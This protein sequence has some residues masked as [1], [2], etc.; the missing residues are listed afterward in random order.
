MIYVGIDNGLYGAIA[1]YRKQLEVYPIPL[2]IKKV[3][4][5]EREF[6]DKELIKNIFLNVFFYDEPSIIVLEEAQPF[7]KEGATSSF[8]TGNQ[9][10]FMEGLLMGMGRKFNIISPK[11]WQKVFG[12]SGKFG[13]TKVQAEKVVNN[14]YP[15]IKTRTERGKLLDGICDAILMEEYAKML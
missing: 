6:Y 8:K 11:H 14:K 3:N 13:D 4:K 1:I 10:G 5:S 2:I 9:Y 15:L 12:I 7:H